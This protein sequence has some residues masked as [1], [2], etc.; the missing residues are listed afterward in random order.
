[1]IKKIKNKLKQQSQG[2]SMLKVLG[3]FSGGRMV[4]TLLRMFGG[5]L[6]TRFVD[7]AT[8]GLFNG[9]GLSQTYAGLLQLGIV[10]G[11]G[12]ELPYF[13][14]KGEKE[15][16]Y[17]LTAVAQFWI[18][19]IATFSFLGMT[20]VAIY[21]LTVGNFK[22]AAGWFTYGIS[23]FFMFYADRYLMSTYR[24][25]KEFNKLALIDVYQSVANCL[26]VGFVY[27]GH[28]YGLCLRNLAMVSTNAV[29]LWKWRPIQVKPKWNKAAFFHLF[30]IGFP[31]LIVGQVN[32]L[33]GAINSSLLLTWM[34]K[35]ELGLYSI[36]LLASSTLILIPQSLSQIVYP[37]MS[38]MLGKGKDIKSLFNFIMKPALLVTVAML[39]IVLIGWWVLPVV[40][41]KLL[42][43]YIAGVE[44]G[45]WAL[46]QVLVL[47]SA[48]VN[49]VFTVVKRQDLYLISAALGFA[50]YYIALMY[51]KQQGLMIVHFSQAILL[52]KFI[53]MVLSYVFLGFLLKKQNQLN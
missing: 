37:R 30:K 28:F 46:L 5:F 15:K 24:T 47:S 33:W 34:G 8:M 14:G 43:N 41:A 32:V 51:F 52:G 2:N 16:A 31:N 26:A 23:I 45:Q 25:N 44:A 22:A 39:P 9:I 19:I 20:A 38:E 12:R 17:H 3:I 53:F 4:S 29:F 13:L 6:A 48:S 49:N 40:T 36:A 7:P 11:I 35:K 42:P 10:N 50:A 21:Q 27:I 1:M 18:I